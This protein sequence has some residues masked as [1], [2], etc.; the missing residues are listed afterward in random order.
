M[1]RLLQINVAARSEYVAVLLALAGLAAFG[2]EPLFYSQLVGDFVARLFA[3]GFLAGRKDVRRASGIAG[4][5]ADRGERVSHTVCAGGAELCAVCVARNI[6][7]RIFYRLAARTVTEK[8]FRL[9]DRQ[10]ADGLCTSL[11]VALVGG[12]MVVSA[13][14]VARGRWEAQQQLGT[15]FDLEANLDMDWNCDSSIGDFCGQDW[16]WADSLDS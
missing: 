13:A 1:V 11:C 2:I 8:P 10:R 16:G 12:A 6:V 4:Y 14:M 9:C 3:G 15:N 7:E 5:A